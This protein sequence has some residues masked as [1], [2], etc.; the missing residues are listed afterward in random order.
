MLNLANP[1]LD[2]Y[3]FRQTQTAITS[4]WF[5]KEGFQWAYQT[6]VFGIPWSVPMEFPLY[7]YLVYIFVKIFNIE[8][9]DLA[10]RIV[11]IAF[12]YA[13]MYPLWQILK[14]LE[15]NKIAIL[16]IFIILVTSP[17]FIFW[18]RTFMIESAGLYFTLMFI[19]YLLRYDTENS[20]SLKIL[21][22]IFI[23]GTFA[24]LTKI[25]TLLVGFIFIF[26]YLLFYGRLK[27]LFSKKN[28]VGIL[29]VGIVITIGLAWNEFANSIKASNPLSSFVVSSNLTKWNFG[30]LAQRLDFANYYQQL[31][32]H[33]KNNI[34]YL[35]LLVIF[36]P[37]LLFCKVEY[38]KLMLIGFL[39][40]IIAFMT[41]FNLYKVHN[42]YWYAN[43]VFVVISLGLLVYF[44]SEKF[45][46]IFYKITLIILVIC[47]NYYGYYSFYY[48][49]Q[50][51]N[52]NNLGPFIIG[53]LIK[54]NTNKSDIILTIGLGWNSAVPYYSERK[55]IMLREHRDVKIEDKE[56]QSVFNKTTKTNNLGAIVNCSSEYKYEDISKIINLDN[57]GVAKTHKCEIYINNSTDSYLKQYLVDNQSLNKKERKFFGNKNEL[58]IIPIDL[59]NIELINA[60]QDKNMFKAKNNDMY[61]IFEIPNKCKNTKEIGL[62]LNLSRQTE[63]FTQIFYKRENERFSNATS[64]KKKF[65][66]GTYIA[67]FLIEREN[68]SYIR[69]DPIEK[70][71]E[72]EIHNI[73]LLCEDK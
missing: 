53:N 64:I 42:Y 20:I 21:S 55:A 59:N 19:M 65:P 60:I 46:N 72:V 14:I 58:N 66:S 73:N 27:T 38:K 7:Q 41:L 70:I 28:I 63:G 39:T 62:E 69:I 61:L 3:G 11:S 16:Y 49:H 51:K 40:F 9:L 13:L 35:L 24:I 23:F 2:Q 36:I 33:M 12:Y 1:L 4:Y 48:K 32:V 17:I 30:T 8:N 5:L 34:S 56:F 67:K 54:N 68:L 29:V 47:I 52:L 26:L 31:F 6:P 71:E 15:V 10:G 18:S 57:F 22:L 45:G 37:G 44:I 25:T 50:I 43:S